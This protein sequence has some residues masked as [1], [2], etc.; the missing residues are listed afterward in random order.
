MPKR[1]LII[2]LL[3]SLLLEGSATTAMAV[4]V[5]PRVLVSLLPLHSL[6]AAVMQGVAVPELLLPGGASPH[7]FALR[8]SQVRA[9]Q[10]ADLIVWIGPEMETFLSRSLSDRHLPGKVLTLADKPELGWLAARAA[11]VLG[12]AENGGGA[13]TEPVKHRHQHADGRDFHFWLSPTRALLM[14]E[15][16]GEELTR[17]DPEH[18]EQ[19]QANT[20]RLGR[21]LE[22]L[23][24]QLRQQ[25]ASVV[26]LPYV[27]FHD[28]YRYFE[29]DFRISPIGVVSVNPERTPGA[30]RVRQIRDEIL[31]SRVRC[32]FSEPQFEPRLVRVLTEG[33]AARTGILD[34]LGAGIMPGPAAYQEL[35][36][37]MGE[38]LVRCLEGR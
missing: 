7:N 27:V 26:N 3:I 20:R 33:T 16:V 1:G 28:A 19:Y 17:I 21:Q 25:L 12:T 35:L 24:V 15:I 6:V 30:R 4:A 23:K 14:A 2:G 37:T 29:D 5:A 38:S 36:K 11:G 10:Q 22:A 13:G 18:A 34:P 32:V 8:P 31:G 9:L